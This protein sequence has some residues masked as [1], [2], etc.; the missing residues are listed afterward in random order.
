LLPKESVLLGALQS[1]PSL[2]QNPQPNPPPQNI[3]IPH[4]KPS[5]KPTSTKHQITNPRKPPSSSGK[6]PLDTACEKPDSLVPATAQTTPQP[7][8]P[9]PK[10]PRLANQPETRAPPTGKGC[11]SEVSKRV[12]R[13]AARAA[14]EQILQE[15]N[16]LNSN[17]INHIINGSKNSNHKWEKLV[18]NKNWSR[19]KNIIM[20]VLE[21]GEVEPYKT[22]TSRIKMIN[23]ELVQVTYKKLLDGTIKIGNAWI[24]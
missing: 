15:L 16:R 1:P 23:H 11:Q 9:A 22:G 20:E 3:K 24:K 13:N 7:S 17:K 18:P 2:T 14:K 10:K 8:A 21:T 6:R 5:T 4:T 19:I 12:T